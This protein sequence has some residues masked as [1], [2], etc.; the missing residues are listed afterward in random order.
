MAKISK[1]DF[2]EI[3]YT[4]KTKEDKVIFDTTD[5]KIAKDNGLYNAEMNYGPVIVC[6]GEG[7][8]LPGLDKQ[9]EGKETEK[10]YTIDLKPEE[11]FGKKDAK[12]IQLVQTSKFLK[13][14]IQPMPGLQINMDGM[15]ATI[16]TVSGGRT[17]VDFNHPLAGK[18]IVYDIKINRLVSDDKEKIKAYL[19]L[20]LGLKEL[21]I[22]M[23]ENNADVKL[24]SDIPK[25][26]KD[27]LNKKISEL[28]PAIKKTEFIIQEEVKKT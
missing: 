19:K 26:A 27:Q 8:V 13:Q 4:G 24:K 10:E 7:Q 1:K 16:K 6:I 21:D 9:L 25:E 18:D 22:D 20:S 14:N 17:L 28:I 11:A 3:E 12:L 15:M 5:E 2:V 23:K